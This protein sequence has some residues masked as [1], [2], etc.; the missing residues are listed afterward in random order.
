MLAILGTLLGNHLIKKFQIEQL[1]IIISIAYSMVYINFVD[2]MPD[3]IFC[4]HYWATHNFFWA[5]SYIFFNR[6]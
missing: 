5:T 1:P 6:C 2:W 3:E 4:A